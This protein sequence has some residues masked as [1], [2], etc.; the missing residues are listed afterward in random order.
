MSYLNPLR[1]HFAGQFQASISTVNNV[2]GNFN[3]DNFKTPADKQ[4]RWTNESNFG[5]FSTFGDAAWRLIGC[6]ITSAFMP[7]GLPS[8]DPILSMIVADSDS[9]VTA[10]LVDLDSEQQLVSEI[11]GLQVRIADGNGKTLLLGDFEPAAFMDIWGRSQGGSS[12][13]GAGAQWQSVLKNLVWADVSEY[14]FLKAL[15]AE[16]A[17]GLLSIK[18]NVDA[19]SMTS[20]D[21]G[22]LRGRITGTIGPASKDEPHQFVRG[23]Q[24]AAVYPPTGGFPVPT[25]N[26]NW[27]V[28]SVDETAGKVYLDLGN[29]IPTTGAAND[30]ANIGD[31]TL[32]TADGSLV[33][34]TLPAITYAGSAWYGRTAGVVEFPIKG[35][36]TAD[37]I[38]TL[39]TS[40][41][42]I[43]GTDPKGNPTGVAEATDGRFV[44]AD[45]FVY[46]LNPLPEEPD[47]S[48]SVPIFATQFGAPLKGVPVSAYFYNDQLQPQGSLFYNV[49]D[50]IS[51]GTPASAVTF[52]DTTPNTDANG[53]TFLLITGSDPGNPRGP[54]DGQVYGIGLNLPGQPQVPA[55]QWQFISLLVW[56]T[57]TPDDPITWWG[58]MQPIFQQYANLY[59]IMSRFLDMGDYNQVSQPHPAHMLYLAFSLDVANPNSMPVTR[60]LSWAKRQAILKWLK[61]PNPNATP[62]PP[63]LEGTKPAP[64][65]RAAAPASALSA[66]APALSAAA[67]ASAPAAAAP[68]GPP[69]GGKT[70][71]L[72]RRHSVLRAQQ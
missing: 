51:V 47:N 4:K 54:I 21:L 33:L 49:G 41:L 35:S 45:K 62:P 14:P 37:Q 40:P 48:V 43:T 24:L 2:S 39:R 5:G 17:D 55:S 10:K 7:G 59:P 29:A 9:K 22:Y 3:P 28:A 50:E 32:Q 52:P 68:A 64:A 44:R 30:L 34:G 42:C 57:F 65:P 19:Y 18:F 66:A 60:D 16:A 56:D 11:W 58:S 27:C 61:G 13:A 71:A 69:K 67:P 1:L 31:L 53:K 63:P 8:S 70:L 25:Q 36:L 15:R 46:R 6:N 38:Q 72:A 12:D 20:T 26:L 23:H